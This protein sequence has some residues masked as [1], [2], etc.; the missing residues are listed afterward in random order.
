[1][2]QN[3]KQQSNKTRLKGALLQN[4]INVIKSHCRRKNH[5]EKSHINLR[6]KQMKTRNSFMGLPVNKSD[7][8]PSKPRHRKKIDDHLQPGKGF[9]QP[10]EDRRIL[11][12][13][14]PDDSLSGDKTD[15]I[16]KKIGCETEEDVKYKQHRVKNIEFSLEQKRSN[17]TIKKAKL[18]SEKIRNILKLSSAKRLDSEIAG[19]VNFQFD[20]PSK[21]AR[22]IVSHDSTVYVKDSCAQLKSRAPIKKQFSTVLRKLRSSGSTEDITG[23]E[24]EQK[25]IAKKLRSSSNKMKSST[26]STLSSCSGCSLKP[27]SKT[28]NWKSKADNGFANSRNN[29]LP[30]KNGK[31]NVLNNRLKLESRKSI[32]SKGI[33]GALVKNSTIENNKT[34]T[35][36]HKTNNLISK[37]R[38]TTS[39]LLY[40]G[41]KNKTFCADEGVKPIVKLDDALTCN[42][43]QKVITGQMQCR[44]TR[45]QIVKQFYTKAAKCER[46]SPILQN[47][48]DDLD[49]RINAKCASKTK[50]RRSIEYISPTFSNELM[51]Y[52]P[53]S[54]ARIVNIGDD[55]EL[56][57]S[58]ISADS[59]SSFPTGLLSQT[60]SYMGSTIDSKTDIVKL[61]PEESLDL[62]S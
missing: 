3:L 45:N 58:L 53:D 6:S 47:V 54:K 19:S 38:S 11:A 14:D 52:P 44:K 8:F 18:D 61:E 27:F 56:Q 30:N 34:N 33:A 36:P 4:S 25:I 2:L 41:L 29:K 62:T 24:T 37:T 55:S 32:V 16:S 40:M 17:C 10:T 46:K 49:F 57:L 39:T 43:S 50:K 15:A 51:H 13:L 23:C 5:I 42:S 59:L 21:E 22:R 31:L 12:M 26:C 7:S 35:S 9:I 28:S 48:E 1:M 60:V 20:L